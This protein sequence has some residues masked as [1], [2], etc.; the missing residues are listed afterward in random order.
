MNRT[1][2]WLSQFWARNWE[3]FSCDYYFCDELNYVSSLCSYDSEIELEL[4]RGKYVCLS[5]HIPVSIGWV[6][7]D[8][9]VS[10]HHAVQG[11]TFILRSAACLTLTFLTTEVKFCTQSLEKSYLLCF[12]NRVAKHIGLF[13]GK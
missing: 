11:R 4:A 12:S 10:K 3:S 13:L 9:F 6:Q 2:F 8:V 7:H 1:A 5:F